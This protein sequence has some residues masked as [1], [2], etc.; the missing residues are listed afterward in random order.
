MSAWVCIVFLKKERRDGAGGKSL[1]R[2]LWTQPAVIR[3]VGNNDPMCMVFSIVVHF[4][5]RN[6]ISTIVHV[7]DVQLLVYLYYEAAV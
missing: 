3:G 1:S 6:H 4:L 7:W 5:S 2:Q